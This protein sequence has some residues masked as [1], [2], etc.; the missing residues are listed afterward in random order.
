MRAWDLCRA[1][2]FAQVQSTYEDDVIGTAAPI[3]GQTGAAVGAVAVAS[4][5]LRITP[6]VQAQIASELMRVS[7]VI[8]GKIG[9]ILPA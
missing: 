5:A 9:G 3:F 6:D 7:Q 4:V 1:N 8:T 2:G